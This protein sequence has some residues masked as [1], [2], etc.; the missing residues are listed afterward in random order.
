[1]TRD[2]KID[3]QPGDVV[4]VGF[5]CRTV[6]LLTNGGAVHYR[7]D[8]YEGLCSVRMWRVWCRGVR[9]FRKDAA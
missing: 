6:L 7:G 5:E 8:R 2:P 3:P 1:M 9:A 4:C